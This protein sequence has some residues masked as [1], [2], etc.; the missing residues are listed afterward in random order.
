MNPYLRILAFSILILFSSC[1]RKS[2]EQ[3][4]EERRQE[5]KN[6][7]G[8][9]Y[10]MFETGD[11]AGLENYVHQEL[12]EHTPDPLIVPTGIEGVKELIQINRTAFPDLRMKVY[13][14]SAEGDMVY[15]HFNFKGTNTGMIR[16]SHPTMKQIDIDGVDVMRIKDGK[17]SEH[18][19]YWDTMKFLNQLGKDG[20]SD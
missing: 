9:I 7:V 18:W 15:S 14:I 5:N 11:L 10:K 16:E 3:K 8:H 12:I 19:G 13:N 2:F 1:E 4:S 20:V 17:I 6:I